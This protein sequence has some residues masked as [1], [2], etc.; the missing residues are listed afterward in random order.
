MDPITAL[1]L[2]SLLTWGTVG[3]G[4]KDVAAIAK[5][6]PPPSHAYR[7]AKMQERQAKQ[8]RKQKVVLP[9]RHRRITLGDLATHWWEDGLEVADAW[10]QNRHETRD[11]RKAKRKEA[12]A[13]KKALVAKGYALLKNR[14]KSPQA[15]EDPA[16]GS[17]AD[18]TSDPVGSLP[19]GAGDNVVQLRPRTDTTATTRGIPVELLLA[20]AA[21]YT[22]HTQGLTEYHRY[23]VE[24][25]DRLEQITNRA[26][27]QKMS[28]A[29]IQ[30]G[31]AAK[32]AC[33]NT[34]AKAA[35]ARTQLTQ[36][37]ETVAEHRKATDSRVDADYVNPN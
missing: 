4:I 20:D 2:A 9:V 13:A 17:G 26:S 27:E 37:H 15:P 32:Q 33:L 21:T 1:I 6:Q 18:Q 3:S 7:M 30:A 10:R 28:A 35:A 29:T 36:A 23:Y 31:M 14:G 19:Q 11:V 34:V 25:A 16:P 8:D 12:R 22:A 5:G 24:I